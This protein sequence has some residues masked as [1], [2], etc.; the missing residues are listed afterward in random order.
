M[1]KALFHKFHTKLTTYARFSMYFQSA[2][3][4]KIP[5]KESDYQH[6]G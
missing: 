3:E 4:L 5:N 1:T 2:E 6:Q